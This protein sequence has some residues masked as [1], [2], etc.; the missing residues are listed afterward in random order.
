[1]RFSAANPLQFWATDQSVGIVR[2]PLFSTLLGAAN[3]MGEGDTLAL[4]GAGHRYADFRSLME[5]NPHGAAHVSFTGFIRSIGTAARDPLF[6]MLHANVDR[7]WAKWQWFHRR[8]DANDPASYNFPGRAGQPGAT[9][10]GHNLDDSMWPWN[11]VTT[12]PRPPTAPGGGFATALTTNAPGNAPL[13]R[14]MID[15]QGVRSPAARL[16]FDYDDVPFEL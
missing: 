1:V 9:R 10:V 5:A 13:V 3:A 7:L 4:G 15:Y 8:F 16:G 14:S 6:F 11:Q 12:P 2:R